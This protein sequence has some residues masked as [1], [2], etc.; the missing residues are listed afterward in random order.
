MPKLFPYFGLLIILVSFITILNK[1]A[2]THDGVADISSAMILINVLFGCSIMIVGIGANKSKTLKYTTFALLFA[3]VSANA[4][5]S[6]SR[7]YFKTYLPKA[8][9]DDRDIDDEFVDKQMPNPETI[10]QFALNN[11]EFGNRVRSYE[12]VGKGN[13]AL[14]GTK[15]IDH[16]SIQ[17][18]LSVDPDTL[19][20]RCRKS[21]ITIKVIKDGGTI[22]KRTLERQHRQASH[23][24]CDERISSL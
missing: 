1:M 14:Y 10:V 19:G 4:V 22:V 3:F 18:S 13:P 5:D 8:I 24:V 20:E 2:S 15:K 23:V 16:R 6:Y 12:S 17:V 9:G 11:V 21:L 7:W